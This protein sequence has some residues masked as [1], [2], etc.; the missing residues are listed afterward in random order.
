M[1]FPHFVRLF[2]VLFCMQSGR[3]D[4]NDSVAVS[5]QA[6]ALRFLDRIHT[7]DS[8]T[9]WPNVR[10]GWFLENLRV[11]VTTPLAM[12]QGSN[13]NFCG[14]AALSYLP[15][16]DNPLGYVKFMLDLYREGH[17]RWG[18]ILFDPSPAV[19]LAG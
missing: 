13:T 2:I 8:S 4:A 11:N 7:L 15:L 12:Y 1:R 5:S 19:R 16:H 10:P 14:Y 9:H 3:A 18:K 6:E 17:A